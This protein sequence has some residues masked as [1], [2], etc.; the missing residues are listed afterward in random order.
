MRRSWLDTVVD[1]LRF[2]PIAKEICHEFSERIIGLAGTPDSLEWFES[3][4]LVYLEK[5]DIDSASRLVET[6]ISFEEIGPRLSE[7]RWRVVLNASLARPELS[8]RF[9]RFLNKAKLD[10]PILQHWIDS[11]IR[12]KEPKDDPLFKSWLRKRC[13]NYCNDVLSESKSKQRKMYSGL[14]ARLY[15]R[16]KWTRGETAMRQK[17]LDVLDHQELYSSSK[18]G[19]VHFLAIL[20]LSLIHI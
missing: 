14:N 6:L 9:S 1:M 13:M 18:S 20:V 7:T 10:S 3:L 16:V 11:E 15:R 4:F 19:L 17:L 5:A 12:N 2:S 8:S